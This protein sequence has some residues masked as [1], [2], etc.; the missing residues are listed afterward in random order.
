[1]C[2]LYLLCYCSDDDATH[3]YSLFAAY[4]AMFL[5]VAAADGSSLSGRQ[6]VE[7][8]HIFTHTHTYAHM[9]L[10]TLLNEFTILRHMPMVKYT[11]KVEYANIRK[12]FVTIFGA[13]EYF[14]KSEY[15]LPIEC[16]ENEE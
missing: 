6:E 12:E 3:I 9:Y 2:L 11:Q 10:C 13:V 4:V 16:Q 14:R 15:K 5:V 1:M 7:L 8:H